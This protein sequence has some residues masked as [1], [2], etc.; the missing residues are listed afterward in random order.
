MRL[1][2]PEIEEEARQDAVMDYVRTLPSSP[3]GHGHNIIPYTS[4]VYIVLEVRDGHRHRYVGWFFVEEE[5]S[6]E[7]PYVYEYK[8]RFGWHVWQ[9]VSDSLPD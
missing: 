5:K 9:L 4:G 8:G 7:M 2:G 1:T 3:D 6:A